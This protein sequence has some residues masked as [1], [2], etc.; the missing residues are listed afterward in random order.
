MNE[1]IFFTPIHDN[2]EADLTRRRTT[3]E[4]P[5]D[6]RADGAP[7]GGGSRKREGMGLEGRGMDHCRSRSIPFQSPPKS[8]TWPV[9]SWNR[10]RSLPFSKKMY[11][12]RRQ[13]V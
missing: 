11:A 12:F 9:A 10:A 1:T 3:G 7:R 6:E 4:S 5:A 2:A 8:F 13:D